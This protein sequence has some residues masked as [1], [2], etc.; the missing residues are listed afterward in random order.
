[1][2]A[3]RYDDA[4]E[5]LRHSSGGNV[6]VRC[7]PGVLVRD[8]RRAIEAVSPAV[9]LRS[10]DFGTEIRGPRKELE[11]VIDRIEGT[12]ARHE[13]APVALD[14]PAESYLEAV[15]E[16]MKQ[17]GVLLVAAESCTAGLVT[18]TITEVPGSSAVL[19]GGFVVYSNEAKIQV[20]VSPEIIEYH[21]AVSREAVIALVEASLARTPANT[22]VA[23]SGIAG[24]GGG[25]DDKPVGTVWIAAAIRDRKVL[26]SRLHFPGERR[27]IRL[28][29]VG[30]CHGAV[31]RVAA[32]LT[33]P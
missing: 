9:G 25:T 32:E 19:W 31:M 5:S 10:F 15:L 13:A 2:Q 12:P 27:A 33:E 20:G 22:A 18:D 3:A 23:V 17:A 28:L 30:A 7:L 8:A 1:M 26:T 29:S 11:W 24:P 4:Q 6:T 21:G 16:R 14:C